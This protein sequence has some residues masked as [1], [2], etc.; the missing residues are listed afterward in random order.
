MSSHEKDFKEPKR[1]QIEKEDLMR[2]RLDTDMSHMTLGADGSR[3]TLIS[4][5][6]TDKKFKTKGEQYEEQ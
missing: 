1:V 2:N 6:A 3:N 4:A 5:D